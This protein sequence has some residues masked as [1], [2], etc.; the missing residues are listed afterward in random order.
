MGARN[1]AQVTKSHCLFLVPR[2]SV[3]GLERHFSGKDCGDSELG[4]FKV[5]SGQLKPQNW[6]SCTLGW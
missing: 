3:W 2:L 1:S 5:I 6:Q 4:V